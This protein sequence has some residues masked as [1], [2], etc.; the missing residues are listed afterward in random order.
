MKRQLRIDIECGEES[1][2][3]KPGKFCQYVVVTRMGSCFHCQLFS[4]MGEGKH[5]LEQLKEKKGWLQRHPD[6]LG[7]EMVTAVP[8]DKYRDRGHRLQEKP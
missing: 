7:S 2:A 6:C 4:K 8:T 1:C 3:S 5:G